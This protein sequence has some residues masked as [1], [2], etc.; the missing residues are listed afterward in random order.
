MGAAASVADAGAIGRGGF[1]AMAYPSVQL[2]AAPVRRMWIPGGDLGTFLTLGAMQQAVNQ[3][4]HHPDVRAAAAA[5]SADADARNPESLWRSLR[6]WIASHSRFRFDPDGVEL[7]RTPV[8]QLRQIRNV[9]VMHGDC[10]DAAVLAATLAKACGARV[11]FTVMGFF[12]E[13]YYRH[14][15][16]SMLVNDR[17]L[18]F[19]VTRPAQSLPIKP[20]RVAHYGV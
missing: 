4:L 3:S 5:A 18:D 12:G 20:T 19:D 11:R 7:V 6:F 13:P 14:V 8:E 1:C 15:Y 16:A 9:G 2:G 10:D 17:W